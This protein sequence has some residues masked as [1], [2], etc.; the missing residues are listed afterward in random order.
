MMTRAD[1]TDR[2]KALSNLALGI[3]RRC[4]ERCTIDR[5]G[6]RCRLSEVRYNEFRLTLSRLI[7][8][9]DRT[10]TLDVRFEGK[11][12]LHV[13]WIPDKVVRTS[14]RPG[15]WEAR[16][17]RYDRTPALAGSASLTD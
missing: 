8:D 5:A 10:S 15:S 7:D 12:V 4:G 6:A 3:I 17:L 1:R 14:Y 9:K 11:T 13:E 16:L 2:M